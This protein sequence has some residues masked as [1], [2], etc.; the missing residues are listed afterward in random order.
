LNL[1]KGQG[2][3]VQNV[4][5]GSPAEKAGVKP[6]DVLVEVNGKPVPDDPGQFTQM[7]GEVKDDAGVDLV[8]IRKGKPETLKGIKLN[9]PPADGRPRP[10]RDGDRERERE[11]ERNRNR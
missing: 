11:R 9:E 6:H 5:P 7:L 8:V 3:V 1:K 4:M 10:P 2:L